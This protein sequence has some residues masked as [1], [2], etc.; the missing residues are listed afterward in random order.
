MAIKNPCEEQDPGPEPSIGL[1]YC[2]PGKVRDEN[3]HCVDAN[4]YR[5]LPEVEVPSRPEPEAEDPFAESTA[6]PPARPRNPNIQDS[7]IEPHVADVPYT[8]ATRDLTTIDES[9]FF[10]IDPNMA[11]RF[12]NNSS[13]WLPQK[14]DQSVV[15]QVDRLRLAL[16]YFLSLVV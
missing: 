12:V 7:E 3:G 5:S 6:T 8:S 13:I 11:E 1:N 10:T 4:L 9:S 14:T 16:F 15:E 2:P